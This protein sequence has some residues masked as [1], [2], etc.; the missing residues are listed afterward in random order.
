[1]QDWITTRNLTVLL[2]GPVIM[3]VWLITYAVL[4]TDVQSEL[5]M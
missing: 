1:M 4:L 2:V 3:P 5:I